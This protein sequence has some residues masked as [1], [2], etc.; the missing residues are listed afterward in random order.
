MSDARPPRGPDFL[1]YPL[2]E[3]PPRL[4]EPAAAPPPP[5]PGLPPAVLTAVAGGAAALLCLLLVT[6]LGGHA[7]TGAVLAVA[8]ALVAVVAA[9]AALASALSPERRTATQ[10]GRAT[11]VVAA[12][13]ALLVLALGDGSP[14][15]AQPPVRVP[16]PAPTAAPTGPAPT[17]APTTPPP[18]TSSPGAVNGF[19][20]PSQPGPPLSQA[21]DDTGTLYGHVVSTAGAPLAG[22][23]VTVTRASAGDTS[24]TPE[25]PLRVVTRTD[26]QGVYRLRLCQLGEG[27]GYTVTISLNGVSARTDLF[28]NAGQTTVY[29][30]ILPVR[31]A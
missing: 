23:T 3:P 24:G 2:P 25:C 13:I 22:V 1:P 4:P 20:V 9:R 31:R 29:D 5:G 8:A 7:A 15:Q 10:A 14:S 17:V 27:L 19:G 18:L 11:G 21:P 30:V 6:W 12:V 16:T 26:A 28:V